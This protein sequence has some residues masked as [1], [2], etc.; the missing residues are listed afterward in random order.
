MTGKI[1]KLS[2]VD[3]S[4][5]RRSRGNTARTVSALAVLVHLL[6]ADAAL[7]LDE[8]I[9][10]RKLLLKSTPR[11]V[12]MARDT[13]IDT[14]GLDPGCPAADS[15][16]TLDD[17]VNSAT[18]TLPCT[19]WSADA[20]GTLYAFSN[21]S[22]PAGPSEVKKVKVKNGSLKVLGNGLGGMPIPNGAATIDA[23]L[24]LAGIS[25]RYCMTFSGAGDGNRLM[26]R[27]SAAGSCPSVQSCEATTAGSCWFLGQ[28]GVSCD[29][30]CA[31]QGRIYDS[32]TAAYAGS[33]GF[34]ADCAAVLDD[35]GVSPGPLSTTAGCSSGLGCLYAPPVGRVR[36]SAPP[37]TSSAS[38]NVNRACACQ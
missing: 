11:L 15:S 2:L 17:G 28:D 18:F 36:C 30:T 34:D 13:S 7:A 5:S 10:G 37:T 16:L 23:V 1:A 26:V 8:P 12:L 38:A 27:D 14:A 32:A 3:R 20:S 19:Y 9:A 25:R 31:T 29:V 21:S 24:N 35:L 6:Q 4:R 33:G 22:A